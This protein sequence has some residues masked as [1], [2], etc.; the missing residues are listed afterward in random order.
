MHSKRFNPSLLDPVS[1]DETDDE[2]GY[3][4]SEIQ[5]KDKA[6][7]DDLRIQEDDSLRLGKRIFSSWNF[8]HAAHSPRLPIL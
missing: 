6:A 4:R 8:A 1:D 2:D 3:G 5:N 7:A